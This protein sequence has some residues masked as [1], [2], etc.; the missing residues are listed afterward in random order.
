MLKNIFIIIVF[1]VFFPGISYSHTYTGMNGFYDGISHPVIG[2]D[3]FLAMISV[4]II[5]AQ[6]GGRAIWTVPSTFVLIMLIAALYWG[7]SGW[8][9]SPYIPIP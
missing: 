9:N 8:F 1:V 2:L 6:I 7:T 5:S 3:H 4:G